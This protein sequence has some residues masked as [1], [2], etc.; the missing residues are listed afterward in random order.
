MAF[1]NP[2]RLVNA[3]LP[4]ETVLALQDQAT[5]LG[6]LATQPSGGG[7]SLNPSGNVF[8]YFNQTGVGNGADTTEDTV[9][10]FSLPANAFDAVGRSCY[11]YAWGSYHADANVKTAKL[12]FGATSI[13]AAASAA[14]NTAWALEMVVGKAG[15]SLQVISSQ[16]IVGTSHG[17]VT[18]S[19]TAT[20]T[21]TAGIVIKLTCQ[22]ATSAVANRVVLNGMFVTFSN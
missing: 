6:N 17:G 13:S 11:I 14:G 20:E 19:A 2:D 7:S 3:G 4:A 15:S 5:G 22:T 10:T 12:Y 8:E 1:N 9:K 18:N 16:S 21:D